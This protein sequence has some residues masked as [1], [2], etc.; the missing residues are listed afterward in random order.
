[1]RLNTIWIGMGIEERFRRLDKEI[2]ENKD[3]C[4]KILMDAEMLD[5]LIEKNG[6]FVLTY[7]LEY[8]GI[9]VDVKGESKFWY[10]NELK[11][12]QRDIEYLKRIIKV[13]RDTV[14]EYSKMGEEL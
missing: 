12:Q 5:Y 9:Q 7:P 13:L 8:R 3:E 11:E 14:N 1:M 4:E 2:D 10:I 6:R